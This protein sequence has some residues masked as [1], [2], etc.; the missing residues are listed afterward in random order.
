MPDP[1]TYREQFA[2]HRCCVLI[3]TYNNCL[4]LAQVID[5]VLCYNDQVIV[6]NDGS[7]DDTLEIL[8]RYPDLEVVSYPQNAGK[9]RALCK[10]FERARK[11]SYCYAITMDSDG[12]HQASDLPVFLEKLQSHPN[13]LIVGARNMGQAGA[14]GT[15]NFGHRFSNF[16]YKLETGID[17]P[18]TQSG[19]RLYPLEAL[20]DMRFFTNRYEFELEVLVRAAWK[21]I[22]V[23]SVPIRVVYPDDRITHFRLVADFAR[24]SLLNIVFVPLALLWYRPLLLLRS[25]KKKNLRELY[26]TYILSSKDSNVKIASSVAL[27]LFMGVA[28][29]WGYQLIVLIFVAHLL[30]L[31]KVIAVVAAHIS[32]PPMIPVIIYVSYQIGGLMVA[33]PAQIEFS[34]GISIEMIKHDLYQYVIGSFGLGVALAVSVGLLAYLLLQLFRRGSLHRH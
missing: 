12:Q 25:L 10:G 29:V 27:G 30:R 33:Q 18:D 9:G 21:G 31:N 22:P 23:M 34:K 20:M 2:R 4:K 5:D 8:S 13:S 28:P 1:A 17:L 6:V 32:I 11:L 15:S 26:H 24:I 16:W 19:Y 14:P 3:P 7:T